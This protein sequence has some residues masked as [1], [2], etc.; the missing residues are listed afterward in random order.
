MKNLLLEGFPGTG[1][2]SLILKLLGERITRAGGFSTVRLHYPDG[3]VA[4]YRVKRACDMACPDE[5]YRD[6]LENVFLRF[7]PDGRVKDEQVFIRFATQA[8]ND[9]ADGAGSPAPSHGAAGEFN[10]HAPA[11]GGRFLLMDEFGGVEIVDSEFCET[12]R[13]AIS[14]DT[15]VIGVLKSRRNSEKMSQNFS[16]GD[17]Y[18][19]A[20]DSLRSFIES[21]DS[22]I[23]DLQEVGVEKAS[24]M[25]LEWMRENLN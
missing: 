3:T 19:R 5:D 13:R 10:S 8:L 11:D 7:L 16:L 22:V 20:Y 9:G 21:A 25:I 2:T 18:M 24:E 4:G 17:D 12:L 14:S 23:V 1:K 6:D 15:P